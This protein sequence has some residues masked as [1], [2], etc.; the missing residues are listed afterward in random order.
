MA[1][2]RKIKIAEQYICKNRYLKQVYLS[3][4]NVF[5]SLAD[6]SNDSGNMIICMR[7]LS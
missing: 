7:I 2:F 3:E 6:I 5:E 4:E 1:K